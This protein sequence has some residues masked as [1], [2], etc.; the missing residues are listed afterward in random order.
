MQIYWILLIVTISIF[1]TGQYSYAIIPQD[2]L[3]VYNQRVPASLKLAKYYAEK[4]NVPKSHLIGINLPEDEK[5]SR[6]KFEQIIPGL[7]SAVQNIKKKGITPV[8]LLFYGI[9]I[10]LKGPPQNRSDKEFIATVNKKIH[11]YK[12]LILQLCRQSDH[13]AK[14]G[15]TGSSNKS[16]GQILSTT[17]ILL[18]ANKAVVRA[19]SYLSTQD[20]KEELFETHLHISSIIIRLK[21]LSI[22]ARHIKDKI[23]A[24][25]K[26]GKSVLMENRTLVKWGTILS[27]QLAESS[28]GGILPEN[29]IERA[30]IVRLSDGIIGELKYWQK[31]KDEYGKNNVTASIDSELTLILR[32]SYQLHSWLPNPFRKEFDDL[33]YIKHIREKTIMVG[34]L[35]GSNP[36]LIRQLI[37]N[38]VDVEDKGL[39]GIF[40]IDARG[41][42]D[43]K[44]KN[45]YYQYDRHLINLA[46]LIKKTGKFKVILDTKTSLFPK[47]SCPEAA[48][49]CGWYSLGKYIDAFKWQKGAVGF[50]IASS[51]ASTLK[52]P[53]SQVWCKRMLEEGVAA[54]LGPVQEPY[55]ASFPLPDTFFPLLLTGKFSIIEVYFKSCPFLSWRQLFI[56]DPLYNPFKKNPVF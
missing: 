32:D 27:Q 25:E 20:L 12:E 40:Y 10:K 13:L 35:D 56:G 18:L 23:M 31:Y 33:P 14:E 30:T 28:F 8:M 54:T 5:I 6:Q 55:L 19:I 1:Y 24:S 7:R 47:D 45:A 11:E 43:N 37:D 4:R 48:L 50:H 42:N 34:R 51:E 52:K 53:F 44:G 9:P 21:G 15:S 39:K 29:A 46:N 49:Y 17:E 22:A 16:P 38:S 36:N 3:L 41:L 2:I 26:G